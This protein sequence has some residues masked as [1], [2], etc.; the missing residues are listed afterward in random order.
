MVDLVNGNVSGVLG[1]S[2]T[3][4]PGSVQ[5]NSSSLA[6]T[7]AERVMPGRPVLKVMIG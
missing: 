5:S 2:R 3:L 7:N 1:L 6:R 4:N